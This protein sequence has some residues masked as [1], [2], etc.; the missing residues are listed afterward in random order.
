VPSPP[1]AVSVVAYV[2]STKLDGSESRVIDRVGNTVIESGLVAIWP[3]PL[4]A[5]TVNS[6]V[7]VAVGTPEIV[8]PTSVS[9]AGN[10]PELIDH[11]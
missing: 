10:I 4:V 1:I 11:E 7:S 8:D 5:L 3:S 2:E 6:L 9:P